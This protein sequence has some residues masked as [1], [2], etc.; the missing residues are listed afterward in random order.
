MKG[1]GD[2]FKATIPLTI[3]NVLKKMGWVEYNRE[4]GHS[5]SDA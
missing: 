5:K 1:G 4:E 3:K 2:S